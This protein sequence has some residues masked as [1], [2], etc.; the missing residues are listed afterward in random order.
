MF[1]F[2]FG[3]LL[4]IGVVALIVLGPE[5]LPKV[6]RTAGL[7]AGKLQHFVS[8]VKAELGK[9][10]EASELADVKKDVEAAAEQFKESLQ[11]VGDAV[12]PAFS[13]QPDASPAWERLPPQR[14]PADFGVDEQGKPLVDMYD[15]DADDYGSDYSLHHAPPPVS[16]KRRAMMQQRDMRPKYRAKP[17]LRVRK[18]R[19]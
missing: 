10:I 7:W 2:G 15:F 13:D 17:K 12:K 16:L 3:E 1:E 4:L 9:Q 14:V 5:R 6:A 19:G 18:R 8:N 11:G